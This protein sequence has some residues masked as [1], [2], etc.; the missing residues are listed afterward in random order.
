MSRK[1][2]RSVATRKRMPIA[3]TNLA[4][5][6]HRPATRELAVV[7]CVLL[8]G[9][10]LRVANLSQAAIEHF[11]EGVYASN[12]WCV[13]GEYPMR[14]LYAPPLLPALVEMSCLLFGATHWGTLAVSLLAGCATVAS[15]WWIARQ[16]FGAAAGVA[17]AT[18][19]GFS[20]FHAAF[21]RSALTDVLL[22]FWLLWA[23][24]FLE[25]S[26]RF[27]NA[28]HVVLAGITTGLAWW[29]K[30]N[31]W[32]PLAIGLTALPL[33]LTADRKERSQIVGRVGLW[34]AVAMIAACVTWPLWASLRA[35]GGYAAVA[36]NHRKYVVGFAG[37]PAS[38]ARQTANLRH[39]DGW[40]TCGGAALAVIV[41]SARRRSLFT[42]AFAATLLA[43]AA[44]FGASVVFAVS[45]VAGIGATVVALRRR[46]S[47][48]DDSV[49]ILNAPSPRY[50]G[51]RAGVR[52][53]RDAEKPLTP[54]LSQSTG[55][56]SHRWIPAWDSLIHLHWL[57][58]CLVAV[59]FGSM[60]VATPMYS[61][62][63]RLTLPWLAAAWF[64]TALAIGA[65]VRWQPAAE[66]GRQKGIAIAGLCAALVATALAAPRLT[67]QQIPAW[68]SRTGLESIAHQIAR[69]IE[70]TNNPSRVIVYV[71][72]EPALFF[73]LR[74]AG[75]PN[76]G[77]V[78][79]LSFAEAG[80]H[81][82]DVTEIFLVTGPHSE[83]DPAFA[84]QMRKV[85]HRLEETATY[86]YLPSDFVLL[87]RMDPRSFVPRDRRAGEPVR[88]WQRR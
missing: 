68:Q 79:D 4:R 42:W 2:L 7:G 46:G 61:P 55:R 14:H 47:E 22:L 25:R 38:L 9:V 3:T 54:A 36:E 72:G 71:Y 26:W 81:P 84:E 32:L 49:A 6:E 24:Y 17:A 39:F 13:T 30:Y 8:A 87:D 56:G 58:V 23:V 1:K 11:D 28:R 78:G 75:L 41:A 63:A 82:P 19:A 85:S 67:A 76:V 51:E 10:I 64:G 73:H 66:L 37:W 33:W 74:A 62:Y 53:L 59:W 43:S 15:V 50:S 5:S 18:L 60:F 27:E 88:L 29:T 48:R 34:V 20:D 65:F 57:P 77:A 12:L 86:S 52:G 45:S 21:S 31:G 83:S 16:W 44:W 80:R 35:V 70:L 69:R 40:L